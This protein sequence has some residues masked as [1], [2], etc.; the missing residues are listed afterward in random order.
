MR[1]FGLVDGQINRYDRP[2]VW[3]GPFDISWEQ[4]NIPD[5]WALVF[6]NFLDELK[7]NSEL[8]TIAADWGTKHVFEGVID[9]ELHTMGRNRGRMP[10]IEVD[11]LNPEVQ[12]NTEQT[13][14]CDMNMVVRLHYRDKN[15]H[16]NRDSILMMVK[17]ICAVIK[18]YSESST[19]QT[20]L[21]VGEIVTGP[22][23]VYVDINIELL[24]V[25]TEGT[26]IA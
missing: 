18:Q 17:K 13:D 9:P 19:W 14:D 22:M 12:T 7:T 1:L 3:G 5:G 25:L 11:W 10:F 23:G 20:N 24:I 26:L 8:T 21:T 4:V 2:M 15:N 16:R 6:N